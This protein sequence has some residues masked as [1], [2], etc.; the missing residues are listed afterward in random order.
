MDAIDNALEEARAAELRRC[1]ALETGDMNVVASLLHPDLIYVHSNGGI[2]DRASWL[3]RISR[4]DIRFLRSERRSLQASRIG[5]VV[6]MSGEIIVVS[7][8]SGHRIET[9]AFLTQAYVRDDSGWRMMLLHAT[10]NA[11]DDRGH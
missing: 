1:R 8:H 4:E 7:E 2:D 10:K 5:D 3:A 6:L 11:R 9:V